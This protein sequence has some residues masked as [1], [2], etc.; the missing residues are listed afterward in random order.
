MNNLWSV[1]FYIV[2]TS[3]GLITLKLGSGAGAP[4]GLM[5]GKFQLSLN[6]YSIIG[7]LLYA[8]SFLFYIYLVSKF[9]LGYI[10]PLT[11]AFVYVIVFIASYFIF[12]EPFTALKIAGI[13]LIIVGL[14]LLSIGK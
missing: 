13:A 10:V 6:A 14:T 7:L 12:K 3:A 5:A 4:I 9:D 1:I 8:T 11:A 2:C